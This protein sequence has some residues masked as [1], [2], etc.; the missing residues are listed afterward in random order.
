MRVR[1]ASIMGP[2]VVPSVAALYAFGQ[3]P[4]WLMP[5]L[6]AALSQYA[7][8]TLT[9]ELITS[10][11][12]TGDMRRLHAEIM[13]W[14]ASRARALPAVGETQVECEFPL[15][16]VFEAVTNAL[17]HRDLRASGTLQI[18]LFPG[19]LEVW[20]PGSP[21]GLSE[22]FEKY[23]ARPGVSLPR[24]PTIAL[25]ARQFGLAQQLGRG[26]AV[27]SETSRRECGHDASLEASKDGVTIVI[28]S[29][30]RNDIW[31]TELTN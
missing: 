23:A 19:R 3:E 22:S 12:A 27:I 5:N 6:G 28:P 10:T 26:L 16:A 15:S 17:V 20:S 18:R 31:R 9:T 8:P 1:L 29:M 21:S 13:A 30:V 2:R 7:G 25:L 4:Q 11:H 14:V 24:N